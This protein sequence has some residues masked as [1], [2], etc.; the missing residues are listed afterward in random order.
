MSRGGRE[1]AAA[2]VEG[3]G[4]LHTA[5]GGSATVEAARMGS[6]RRRCTRKRGGRC[7]YE[8]ADESV[9]SIC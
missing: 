3:G 8:V 6:G 2:A 9:M 1:R 4:G 7:F 5:V